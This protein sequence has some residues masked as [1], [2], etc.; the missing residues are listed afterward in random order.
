MGGLP[1]LRDGDAAQQRRGGRRHG[2]GIFTG[3]ELGTEQRRSVA[4]V[5]KASGAL[6]RNTSILVQACQLFTNMYV[7]ANWCSMLAL[8]AGVLPVVRPFDRKVADV[9]HSETCL[10]NMNALYELV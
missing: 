6:V 2:L 4:C 3:R 7:R 8:I 5:P 1:E 10:S 9:N